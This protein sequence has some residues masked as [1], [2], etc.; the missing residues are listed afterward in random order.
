MKPSGVKKADKKEQNKSEK[1]LRVVLAGMGVLIVGLVVAIVVVASTRGG[2]QEV[3]EKPTEDETI[4]TE[5]VLEEYN[6]ASSEIAAIIRKAGVTDESYVL[7]TYK[8][9]ASKVKDKVV[10]MM[11]KMDYLNMKMMYDTNKEHGEELLEEA[12]RID[13]SLRTIKSGVIVLNMAEYYGNE[14]IQKDYEKRLE[15]R[16][17]NEGVDTDLETVG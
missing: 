16:E 4:V 12:M 3:V 11:L 10:S 13:A 8:S 14:E 7:S 9:Y 17:K 5:K 1:T 2:K 6:E 15:V